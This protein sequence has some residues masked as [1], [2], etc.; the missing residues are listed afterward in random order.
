MSREPFSDDLRDARDTPSYRSTSGRAAHRSNT[1]GEGRPPRGASATYVR[2]RSQRDESRSESSR[3]YYVRD[4]A[5]WLRDSEIRSLTEV[6]KFRVIAAPDLARYAYWG[7]QERM[8]RDVRHLSRQG[9]VT[10]QTL[11]VSGRQL[12]RVLTLT[13]S[14]HRLLNGAVRLPEGQAI[15]HGLRKPREVK[16]DADLYRL[17]QKEASRI[18]QIGGRPLRVILDYELEKNLNRDFALL[19][20]DREEEGRKREIAEKHGL[21]V[22]NGKVPVPDMRVEYETAESEIRHADLELATRDYRPRALV[23]K[24]RAGFSLYGRP[25]DVSRLRRILDDREITAALRSL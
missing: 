17:Y 8:E 1:L 2:H 21:R 4:R 15:Y 18:E 7:D 12:L 11:E 14:G 10:D 9:L 24:A 16:H 6:G 23:E 20:A 5:Y 22:V 25:E 13:E 19:G 3:T